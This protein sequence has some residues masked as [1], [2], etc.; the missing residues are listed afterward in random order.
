MSNVMYRIH[1]V[2]ARKDDTSYTY[3]YVYI[4]ICMCM[5]TIVILQMYSRLC[6]SR[7]E[8]RN[9]ASIREILMAR[10]NYCRI[11]F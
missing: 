11:R 6:Y 3:V 2:K 8:D 7:R 10:V 9:L 1:G 5:C 4:Y